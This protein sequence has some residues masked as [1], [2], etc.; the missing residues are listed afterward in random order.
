MCEYQ[1]KFA[2]PS[3][4]YDLSCD[5][6]SWGVYHAK[7]KC[8]DSFFGVNRTM[9]VLDEGGASHAYKEIT[10]QPG[11][12]YV[13]TVKM[14]LAPDGVCD[15]PAPAK[16]KKCS[17]S[18]IICSSGY[19]S[20]YFKTGDCIV[21]LS[22]FNFSSVCDE[23]PLPPP[24]GLLKPFTEVLPNFDVAGKP[25]PV[26]ASAL[27]CATD[28][29][30]TLQPSCTFTMPTSLTEEI[31]KRQTFSLNFWVR[32]IPGSNSF[33]PSIK[34]FSSVAPR[35]VL[36]EI[37]T[38]NN[39]GS[40]P[41]MLEA[42][43]YY[44]C[45]SDPSLAG[46]SSRAGYR[47][48]FAFQQGMPTDKWVKLTLSVGPFGYPTR[49]DGAMFAVDGVVQTLAKRSDKVGFCMPASGDFVQA[50]VMYPSMLISPIKIRVENMEA[51]VVQREYYSQY[52]AAKNW[53]GPRLRDDI[54]FAKSAV[55][56]T[57][58]PYSLP[59]VLIAPVRVPHAIATEHG[60]TNAMLARIRSEF[61][62]CW[63]VGCAVVC[64]HCYCNFKSSTDLARRHLLR[65]TWISRMPRSSRNAAQERTPA[66]LQGR[67]A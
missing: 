20:K 9:Q 63:V 54:A 65:S 57:V 19:S 23:Q 5:P 52:A 43:L 45:G 36:L 39:N 31:V 1:A 41:D 27:Q 11:E 56:V 55:A 40:L 35:Q 28:I 37:V 53:G 48:V 7:V 59:A 4:D 26:G 8:L 51:R 17:P 49:T 61:C 2:G 10:V 25:V 42:R 6:A 13:V 12:S 50:V 24:S 32:A 30:S 58:K 38:S 15:Q 46:D 66:L 18:V 22:P 34:L 14:L 44:N 29:V 21:N 60:G 67:G 47:F 16:Y 64:S 3:A 62:V 33:R